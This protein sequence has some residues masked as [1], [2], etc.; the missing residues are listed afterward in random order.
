MSRFSAV[1]SPPGRLPRAQQGARMQRIGVLSPYAADNP[2]AK[3]RIGA[4]LQE[5]QRLGWT[6]G[7]NLR[8]DFRWT[9]GDAGQ[10]RRYSEELVA[11]APEAI[12][13]TSSAP[14][15]ALRQATRTVPIVFVAVADPVEGGAVASLARP[16]GNTT[17]F[18]PLEYGTSAKWLELL[19]QMVPSVTRVAVLRAASP[20][21]KGQLSAIQSVAHALGVEL[22]P[23]DGN[24]A[25]EI[26]RAI[27][28]F[29][30]A[31]N[32]GLIAPAIPPT[33]IHRELI[34]ALAAR[35]RLPAIYAFRSHV[36]S[37]GLMSY[38][39]DPVDPYRRAAS[40]ID[41]ILKGAKPADLPV[42]TPTKYVFAVNLKTAKALGLTVPT[43][44]LLRADEV[45]E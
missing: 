28:V 36:A 14:L 21:S 13:V 41:R 32:G 22:N 34:I 7:R 30:R 37:G 23:V 20:G 16:G 38:G 12:L 31:S 27:A 2:D 26:E 42:Q 25:A 9:E 45:I 6:E 43:S 33:I 10:L 4:F 3:A 1:R 8:I 18:T 19:K 15:A 35:H 5:L 29:A 40:Y 44:I 39:S 24:E 11:L 17:G